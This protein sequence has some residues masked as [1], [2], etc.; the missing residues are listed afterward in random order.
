[1]IPQ[2]VT[3]ELLGWLRGTRLVPFVVVHANHPRELDGEVEQ[4]LARLVDAGIPVLNQS[5]LL[6]GVNADVDTLVELSRRLLDCRVM[7]YY[8][9]QLDRVAGAAHFET[10]VE[11]GLRLIQQMADRLPGYAVPKYVREVPG[12]PAKVRMA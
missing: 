1:V 10:P 9:H 4:S 11:V 6:Q 8:L 3:D 7:P 12:A 5:V 2:R